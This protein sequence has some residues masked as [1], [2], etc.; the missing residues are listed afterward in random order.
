MARFGPWLE[1]FSVQKSLNP[2]KLF[3][4][5]AGCRAIP[6]F[7]REELLHLVAFCLQK[8]LE[9]CPLLEERQILLPRGCTDFI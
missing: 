5:N 6:I 3:Q 1:P 7:P 4:K 2:F 9:P 8:L